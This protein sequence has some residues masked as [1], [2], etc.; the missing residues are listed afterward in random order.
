MMPRG[1]KLN[2]GGKKIS[3]HQISQFIRIVQ[4]GYIIIK[5]DPEPIIKYVEKQDV[6]PGVKKDLT[7]N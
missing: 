7:Q 5:C 6:K 1:L 4:P 2:I 3:N